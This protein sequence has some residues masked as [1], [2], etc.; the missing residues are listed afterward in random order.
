MR[1]NRKTVEVKWF[2]NKAVTMAS[3]YVGTEATDAVEHYDCLVRQHVDVSRRNIVRLYNQYLEGIEK[4]DMI[5]WLCKLT[6]RLRR[7][8][9]YL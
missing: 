4:L 3:S 1:E 6:L 7:W 8:C 2:D 5:R 9:I